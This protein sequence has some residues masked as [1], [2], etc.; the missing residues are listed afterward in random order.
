M[1]NILSVSPMSSQ[2]L[3]VAHHSVKWGSK[4]G[5]VRSLLPIQYWSVVL[6]PG[7]HRAGEHQCHLVPPGNPVY[8]YM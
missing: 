2:N 8:Y 5:V 1:S 7:F 4:V 3:Y 6:I